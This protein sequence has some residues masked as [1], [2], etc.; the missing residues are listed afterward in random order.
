M[1][2]YWLLL[3]VFSTGALLS[4]TRS[5]GSNE[6]PW[7]LALAGIGT[8]LMIGFRYKV[9]ADWE[10]YRLIFWEMRFLGLEG[11]V[12]RS[13]PAFGLLN[14]VVRK[15]GLQIWVVNFVC[16]AIFVYGLVR[17]AAQ[18]TN[19]WLAMALAVPYLVIV[20]GMG[21][22]RQATA[23]GLVF[24]ALVAFN[25]QSAVRFLFWMLAAAMFHRSALLLLP[26]IAISYS[27]NRL[28]TIGL[29]AAATAIG[30]FF[31]VAP[32]IDTYIDRYSGREQGTIES[33][34]TFVRLIMNA[35]PALLF[36]TMQ[37][38]FPSATSAM[39]TWRNLSI[40]AFVS[41]GVYAY[42]G[43]NTAID[44]LSLYLAPL[45]VFVFGNL[46]YI[47]GG[48]RGPSRISIVFVL[49]YAVAIQ[50]VWLFFAANAKYW[51]PYRVF[52]L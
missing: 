32:E 11:A 26:L 42:L 29:A 17:F 19:P 48:E 16:A 50:A 21:Y 5:A 39:T 31:I 23:L 28:M 43:A 22:N 2:P 12:L 8:V 33:E 10:P 14:W 7:L 46:P 1:F 13:D 9:G 49:L 41:L 52:P 45:Q 20:V 38:R 47:F 40:L 35:L 18:Q 3:A 6:V 4:R 27:R 24:L 25:N 15:A 36:L 34:G 30:Y 51:L 44:R 37:K